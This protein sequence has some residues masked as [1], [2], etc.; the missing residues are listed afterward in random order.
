MRSGGHALRN[1]QIAIGLVAVAGLV[2]LVVH[3]GEGRA[4]VRLVEEA[5]PWWLVLALGLQAGTYLTQAG[6]WHAVLTRAGESSPLRR[7]YALSVVA[8]FTSQ[9]IP[10][11]G[12][13][14]TFV[15]VRVLEAWGL[16][17]SAT[18]AAVLVNLTVYYAAYGLFVSLALVVLMITTTSPR[19]SSGCRPPSS[20]SAPPWPLEFFG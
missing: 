13:A 16:P 6:V 4:F 5:E 19:S 8:L 15:V 10:S 18:M 9:S 14:G 11:A 1:V 20:C 17:T 7:L 3:F 12:L 2:T